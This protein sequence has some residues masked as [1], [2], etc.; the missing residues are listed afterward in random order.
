MFVFEKR[1]SLFY[2]LLTVDRIL[3]AV[4]LKKIVLLIF[5]VGPL[6]QGV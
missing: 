3:K 2:E 4:L 1:I 5:R 6:T